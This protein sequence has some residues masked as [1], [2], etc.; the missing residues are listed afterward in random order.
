M[1]IGSQNLRYGKVHLAVKYRLGELAREP[2]CPL[3]RHSCLAARTEAACLAAEMKQPLRSTVQ[4][5]DRSEAVGASARSDGTWVT[6][7]LDNPSA[8]LQCGWIKWKA[9]GS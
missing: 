9:Q 7:A 2:S 5:L 4:A 8:S 1:E 3:F 6:L